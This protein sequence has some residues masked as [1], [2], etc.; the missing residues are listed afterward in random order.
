LI[1]AAQRL[2]AVV[3]SGPRIDSPV[4]LAAAPSN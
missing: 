2:R 3:R 1:S 4:P